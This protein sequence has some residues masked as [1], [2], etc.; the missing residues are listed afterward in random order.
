[1]KKLYLPIL[2]L[3]CI[4]MILPGCK[5][6]PSNGDASSASESSQTE[7]TLSPNAFP[8]SSA[9]VVRPYQT[10]NLMIAASQSLNS[11][12]GDLCGTKIQLKDDFVSNV[13]KV[14]PK[15]YEIL[16]GETNREETALAKEKLKGEEF[17]YHIGRYGNKLV[18]VGT[19]V[20]MTVQGI[21]DFLSNDV[22]S[23]LNN[24][25]LEIPADYSYIKHSDAVNVINAGATSYK[26]VTSMSFQGTAVTENINK[27]NNAL[28]EI[29][30]KSIAVSIDTQS[31]TASRNETSKE[32]LLGYTYYP[33]TQNYI[34][35]LSYNEYGFAID[36]NK[37]VIFGFSDEQVAKAI[38]LFMTVVKDNLQSDKTLRL[39]ADLMIHLPNRALNLDLPYYPDGAQKLMAVGGG[40]MIYVSNTSQK[41]FDSYDDILKA[42]GFEFYTE[43]KIG[44]NS[45][46]TYTKNDLVVNVSFD[47]SENTTRLVVDDETALPP[48]AE[49]N[50]Y[51]ATVNTQMTQVGLNHMKQDTGMSYFLRLSDGR[52]IVF[53]GGADDFDEHHKL[54][55]LML[56]QCKAGEQPVI[57]AWF[58]SHAHADHYQVF[59]SFASAYAK[60]ITIQRVIFNLPPSNL[61]ELSAS[62][63]IHIEATYKGIK[64]MVGA[65]VTYARTGQQFHIGNAVI[66]V[67]FSPE[68]AY[69]STIKSF[70]DS[71]VVYRITCEGQT[72]MMLGDTETLG[73][74]VL[75]RRYGGN[76]KSDIMQIAHH[77]YNGGSDALFR[78]VNPEIVLW[79]CPDHWYHETLTWECNQFIVTSQ[80]VKEIINAGHGTSVISLPYTAQTYTDPVYTNGEVIYH[81][82]F[83]DMKYIYETGWFSVYSLTESMNY[84]EVN[85]ERLSGDRG[86]R[87]KGYTNS[88]LCILRPDELKTVTAYTLQMSLNVSSL[89]NGFGV[90]Y[91][92]ASPIDSTN[93][94]YYSLEQTGS[95]V[96]TMEVDRGAGTTRVLI[97]GEEI[98][99]LTNNSNDA[100]GIIFNSMNSDVFVGEISVTAG[101]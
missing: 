61:A 7:E 96:L 65:E 91:N 50:A 90:W 40:N 37:I 26:I 85:L 28:R 95:F 64:N 58:L 80:N 13:D 44:R 18:I 49:D 17:A 19:T 21:H 76:L 83:E 23:K 43:N 88:T 82:D 97:D 63:K 22:A 54:Y 38:D 60:E 24:G 71:S 16:V 29:T 30:S 86:I 2:V 6:R 78:A 101:I 79:P 93:R 45:F 94:A 8:I 53:D 77:G 69:P 57:A 81:E 68:D 84:T 48:R 52:F 87:M 42:D 11:K 34:K 33:Q 92:D 36:G 14:D 3:L 59:V 99:L 4:G 75:C 25:M 39:P 9:I 62:D 27:L 5:N 98:A 15:A 56:E 51:T 20:E 73:A 10:T 32:I 66:D 47:P 70:N 89:G 41:S 74:S 46:A 72:I 100:G 31:E 55:N 1:M 12:L 67:L 35:Q